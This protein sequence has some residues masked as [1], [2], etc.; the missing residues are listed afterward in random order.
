MRNYLL[1]QM[2]RLRMDFIW[3]SVAGNQVETQNNLAKACSSWKLHFPM[4][5]QCVQ[6]LP[7][8]LGADTSKTPLRRFTEIHG[9]LRNLPESPESLGVRRS[10]L[11]S[12]GASRNLTDIHG[13]RGDPRSPAEY[14]GAS[15][16][17]MESRGVLR[18]L[19]ESGGVWRSLAESSGV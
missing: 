7:R 18:S 10:P 14:C 3:L 13:V 4:M 1:W 16:S 12:R 8:V 2:E 17:P 11:E 19:A 15:W 9:V 5:L 6:A